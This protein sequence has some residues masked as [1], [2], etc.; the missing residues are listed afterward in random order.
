MPCPENLLGYSFIIKGKVGRGRRPS[1]SFLNR[2]HASNISSSFRLGRG[3]F[4]PF[5]VKLGTQISVFHGCK[6]CVLTTE[7]TGHGVGLTIVVIQS[8]S[9]V[10]LFPTVAVV[11]LFWSCL[12]LLL[13]S[14]HACFCG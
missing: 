6:E 2:H 13:Q 3:V 8:L 10:Q 9:R 5:M 11:L 1:L 7:L 4:F 14:Q 12:T